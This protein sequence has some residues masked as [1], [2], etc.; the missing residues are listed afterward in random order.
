M[1]ISSKDLGSAMFSS[2]GLPEFPSV[3]WGVDRL[4]ETMDVAEASKVNYFLCHS[5]FY[6]PGAVRGYHPHSF[7]PLVGSLSR[8][9]S[10]PPPCL[11]GRM[12][13]RDW[14]CSSRDC[15]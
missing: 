15:G 6:L 7:R 11:Q 14:G 9:S 2:L 12:R 1:I 5:E 13:G 4:N 3:K 10:S 8:V